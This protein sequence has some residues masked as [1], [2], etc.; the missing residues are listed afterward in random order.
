MALERVGVQAVI[1]GLSPYLAGIKSMDSAQT[2]LGASATDAANKS[3]KLGS[4]LKTLAIA[5]AGAAVAYIGLRGL[6]DVITTTQKLGMSIEKLSRETG[7]SAEGVSQMLSSFKHVGQDASYASGA[8]G[9]FAKKL[10]GISDEETGV[11]TGGKSTAQIL[12]DIGVKAT[13]ASGNLLPI[14]DILGPLADRFQAMPNSLE[15]TGLAMQLFGRSGKDMIP[16]L[17]LGSQ[18]LGDL[19]SQAD[20]LG[21]VLTTKNIASIKA[22]TFAQRDMQQ[23]ITGVK[24]QIGLALMPVLTK[25]M[26]GFVD[27]QPTIRE[28]VGTIIDGFG[29]VIAAVKPVMQPVGDL[30]GLLGRRDLIAIFAAI[31][32]AIVAGFVAIGVAATASFIATNAAL[33]GIPIA[34]AAIVT[35]ITLLVRHWDAVWTGLQKAPAAILDWLRNNWGRVLI[36]II[37]GPI[38]ILVMNWRKIW[39]HMPDPVRDVMNFIAKIVGNIVSWIMDRFADLIGRIIDV[40]EE[41]NKLPFISIDLSGLRDLEAT[42]HK[43]ISL[44]QT[45]AA[46]SLS[47]VVGGMF[48]TLTKW[49]DEAR[50][51]IEA[52]VPALDD[53]KGAADGAGD[54]NADAA[55]KTQD[56]IDRLKELSDLFSTLTGNLDAYTSAIDK[57]LSLPSR[58]S[59]EEDVRLAELKLQLLDEEAAAEEGKLRRE[60]QI[61]DIQSQLNRIQGKGNELLEKKLQAQIER[62]EAGKTPEGKALDDTQKQIDLLEHDKDRRA[63]VRDLDRARAIAADQTLLSEQQILDTVDTLIATIP[64][65][66]SEQLANITAAQVWMGVNEQ[67]AGQYAAMWIQLKDI[68]AM[69]AVIAGAPTGQTES[70]WGFVKGQ[71]VYTPG[72]QYGGIVPG[73]VGRPVMAMVHGGERIIPPTSQNWSLP[74]SVSIQ[75]MDWPAIKGQVLSQVDNALERARTQ[76]FKGGNS[77]GSGIG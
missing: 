59:A 21:V 61:A 16:F 64:G 76:S 56:L 63:A 15:K 11:T 70:G 4:Q 3:S 2:R 44:V 6:E 25:L 74:I 73:P 54:A 68:A 18:G 17:N 45:E 23:A 69:Q 26:K 19:A 31:S 24:V 27:V 49:G 39:D 10:K 52:V 36:A 7:L 34:V 43:G 55:D 5:A 30:F 8:I 51:K 77:L 32:A 46:K 42:L 75:G 9:I 12:A 60:K 33:L 72:F 29:Q 48:K 37:T 67:I 58:E 71:W 57:L 53:Y 1:E 38:G 62:L 40:A 47:D 41:L 66:T 13:D 50:A 28:F 65:I 20:K 14:M 22:F 35:A